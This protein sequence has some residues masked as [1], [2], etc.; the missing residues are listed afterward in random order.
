M[1]TNSA[2][3]QEQ[4]V[5]CVVTCRSSPNDADVV[6]SS[7]IFLTPS[8][9]LAPGC[10]L[11]NI[12][13]DEVCDLRS[14]STATFEVTVAKADSSSMQTIKAECISTW[15][16]KKLMDVINK[17]FSH[18]VQPYSSKTSSEERFHVDLISTFLLLK[19][20][21]PLNDALC[22]KDLK[23]MRELSAASDLLVCSTPF[24]GSHVNSFYNSWTSGIVSKVI[25]SGVAFLSDASCVPGGQGGLVYLKGSMAPAGVVLYPVVWRVDESTGLS[26]IG[27]I[28]VI[29]ESLFNNI[30]GDLLDELTNSGLKTIDSQSVKDG[31]ISSSSRIIRVRYGRSWG[32]G[33]LLSD[34]YVLTCAHIFNGRSGSLSVEFQSEHL[35]ATIVFR[36]AA[37]NRLDVAI[38]K[39]T[40]KL[41]GIDILL[42]IPMI[43]VGVEVTARGYGIFRHEPVVNVS[44]GIIAKCHSINSCAY[45]LVTTCKVHPG[46][47]GGAITDKSGNILA[48]ITSNTYDATNKIVYNDVS[49]GLSLEILYP[50]IVRLCCLDDL[51]GFKKLEE[52]LKGITVSSLL[53]SKL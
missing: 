40:E 8:Y 35:S 7:A 37:E 44:S 31:S 23:E 13:A 17:L 19:L 30:K 53:H 28:N 10:L 52:Y 36:S 11:G 1:S 20:N 14:A 12:S 18:D 51:N 32:S 39:L 9:V 46:S 3:L 6:S 2:M 43:R 47:S 22:L 24:G 26:L 38:L 48:M 4:E 50:S 42:S 5:T 15:K 41:D 16:C 27:S 33:I 21:S 34:T 25:E 49:L 29:I 45:T